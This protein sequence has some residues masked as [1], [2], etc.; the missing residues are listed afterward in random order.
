MLQEKIGG[1]FLGKLV[2]GKVEYYNFAYD[3][4]QAKVFCGA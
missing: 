1:G 3:I 4:L 2:R